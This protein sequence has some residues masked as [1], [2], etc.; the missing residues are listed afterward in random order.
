[1]VQFEL[2]GVLSLYLVAILAVAVVIYLR[3]LG[4]SRYDFISARASSAPAAPAAHPWLRTGLTVLVVLV[5]LGIPVGSSAQVSLSHSISG[6]LTAE[7]FTLDHYVEVFDGS[8]RMMEGAVHSLTIAA[9]AALLTTVLGFAIA[10][11]ITFTGFRGRGLIDLAGTATLAIPGIVLAVGYIFVWNQPVLEPLG[12]G[13]YG[14]PVL[15]VLAAVASA[16]P[17]AIRLQLGALAQVPGSLLTAAGLSGAGLLTRLRTVLVPLVAAA[18]VSA[19]AAVFALSVFDLAATTMLAPPNYVTLPVEILLEFDRGRYG[20]ATAGALFAA[21]I[22]VVAALVATRVGTW[23]LSQA[24]G[25]PSPDPGR[26]GHDHD[27]DDDHEPDDDTP[28][29]PGR[30]VLV[31]STSGGDR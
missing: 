14:R 22:V 5:V 31:G 17:I 28:P 19:L 24:G 6:G 3:L 13:L 7:N 25:S 29:G 23:L 20:Y 9:S 1:P 21:A 2:A 27:H 26:R 15:L 16:L 10:V 4:R 11:L 8:G 12:L 30:P 18:V